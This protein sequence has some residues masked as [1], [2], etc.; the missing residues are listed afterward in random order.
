M[1][2]QLVSNYHVNAVLIQTEGYV[3]TFTAPRAIILLV[4]MM[5]RYSLGKIGATVMIKNDSFVDDMK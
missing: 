1:S 4:I 5:L 3:L 2:L